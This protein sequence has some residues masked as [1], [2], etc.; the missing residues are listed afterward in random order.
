MRTGH[1]LPRLVMGA[2]RATVMLAGARITLRSITPEQVLRRNMDTGAKLAGAARAPADPQATARRC[3]EAGFFISR[4]ANRVPWRSDCLVQAL[5]G[6]NWLAQEGI[7]CEIVVG[8]AKQ[9]DGSFLSHA[10][11]RH[12]KQIVLGGD[13]SRYNPLLETGPRT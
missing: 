1:S 3:E 9:D 10:W 2:L 7:A 5:A 11:L 13:I 8:T 6:Q 4:M 12:G